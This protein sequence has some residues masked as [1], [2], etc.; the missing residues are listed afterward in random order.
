MHP[1][2]RPRAR[3]EVKGDLGRALELAV[4]PAG[5]DRVAL[6]NHRQELLL[7]DLK[8][9]TVETVDRS[10]SRPDRRD[11][12]VARRPLAGV[13]LRHERGR[14]RTSR[15]STRLSGQGARGHASRLPRRAARLRPGREV[16]LLRLGPRVR[17]RLRQPLLRPRLPARAA[18]LPRALAQ[19][20]RLAVRRRDARAAGPGGR[21][22]RARRRTRARPATRR[23]RPRSRSTST[24]SRT[25]SSPFPVPEGRYV[26]VAG[27][28]GRALFAS[29]PVE[30]SLDADWLEPGR[31][32]RA[33]C[34]S[35]PTTSRRTRSSSSYGAI[36]EL[37][38]LHGRLD[39]GPARR[40]R[41]RAL[42][43]SVKS[44]G[45][46]E[47]GEGRRESGWVDLAGSRLEVVPPDEWRQM[48]RE[49]WRLQRDQF[50]TPDMSGVDWQAR[51]RPLP[52]ARRPRRQPLRVLATCAGR[53]RASSARRHCYEIGGDYRPGPP[54][55]RASSAP[56]SSTGRKTRHLASS[57]ASRGATP[58]IRTTP[59]RWPR[60]GSASRRA[61][62][63]SRWPARRSGAKRS[64]ERVPR[65]P[66]RAARRR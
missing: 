31:A 16:P 40:Q 49:A 55:S 41:V 17:S 25:A 35:R 59:R 50:W 37:R 38:P 29:E 18:A 44:D 26:Q 34:G 22:R 57:T 65:E 30:G 46:A 23:S 42:P 43:A 54:G 15:C 14:C 20:P 60:P 13:R 48:F 45:A 4:A 10:A 53:C 24:G 3:R 19:G 11:R 7:V 28:A 62:R 39:P 66:G 56:T 8:A 2:G 33:A 1:R 52:A 63:S 36:T 58:G 32:A 9:R 64:P 5:A 51:P 12:L 6:A 61:T 21:R 47:G 27:A